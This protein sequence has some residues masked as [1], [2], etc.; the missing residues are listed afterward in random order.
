MNLSFTTVDVFT[1]TQF[2]GNPLA[3]VRDDAGALTTEQMQA[4]AAEFN[5]SETAFV[6]PPKDAAHTAEVRIFTPRFEMPFAGH[7]NVGTAFVLGRAGEACGRPIR[8][9]RLVFEEQAG[10][11]AIDLLRDGTDVAGARVAAPQPLSLGKRIA[12]ETIAAACTLPPDAIALD[13]HMPCIASCGARFILAEVKDR[14]VLAAAT[15]RTD[16]FSRHFAAESTN[17]VMLYTRVDEGHVSIRCRMFA[18]LHGIAEDPATGSAGVALVGLLAQLRP[19]ADLT[20]DLTILQGVEMGRPSRLEARAVKR[21]GTV[22]DTAIGG[23]CVPV[24]D[25]VLKLS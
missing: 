17:S 4:I 13:R 9:D 22:T 19:E 14:S 25:G 1:T 16:M 8:G 12:P 10:L 18:P 20:L 6:R 23:R 3:V 15:P 5:L 21:G 11:V 24:M 7:P 2:G